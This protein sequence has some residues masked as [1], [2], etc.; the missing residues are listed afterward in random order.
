MGK[1]IE[2]LIESDLEEKSME[3]PHEEAL[4]ELTTMA[5]KANALSDKIALYET[6]LKEL[7]GEYNMLINNTIPDLFDSLQLSEIKLAN[8]VKVSIQRKFSA[9]I[10]EDNKFFC[11]KWLR[12]NGH[13]GIIKHAITVD[14][15]KNKLLYDK[16]IELLGMGGIDYED[17]QTVHPQTLN[18]FCKEQIEQGVDFPMNEF[19]V[20]PIRI[21]KFK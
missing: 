20:F 13:D 8:G 18:A 10:S 17:K 2:D 21:T 1:K 11:F 19:K 15:G 12:D 14:V 16:T 9:S 5:L 6:K 7:T 3:L 4:K